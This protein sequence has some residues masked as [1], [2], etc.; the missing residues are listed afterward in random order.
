M[1]GLIHT[2][3]SVS[4]DITV[5]HSFRIPRFL[6]SSGLPSLFVITSAIWHDRFGRPAMRGRSHVDLRHARLRNRCGNCHGPFT[7]VTW[8]EE[9]RDSAIGDTSHRVAKERR[10]GDGGGLNVGSVHRRRR[11]TRVFQ[12][13][14]SALSGQI[15]PLVRIFPSERRNESSSHKVSGRM[16]APLIS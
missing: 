6:R 13:G 7:I 15:L 3:V 2:F 12:V 8:I 14:H 1:A 16:P 9:V 4:G 10:A 5:R 11:T